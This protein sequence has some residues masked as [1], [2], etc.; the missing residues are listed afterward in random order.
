MPA[1]LLE[2]GSII[3]RDEEV[4]MSSSERRDIINAAVIAAVE[5]FCDAHTPRHEVAVAA[6]PRA[7]YS[8]SSV[9]SGKPP[10]H[11]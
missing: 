3:N 2:A 6:P 8:T 1:V 5:T 9:A 11:R 4:Q 10:I 7:M